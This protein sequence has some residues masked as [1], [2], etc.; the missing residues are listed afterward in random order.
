MNWTDFKQELKG[1]ICREKPKKKRQQLPRSSLIY[2]IYKI[3]M[4]NIIIITLHGRGSGLTIFFSRI[5]LIS[6]QAGKSLMWRDTSAS[7]KEKEK[8]KSIVPKIRD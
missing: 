2:I 1:A 3:K 8:E 7:K 5:A 4:H 6:I